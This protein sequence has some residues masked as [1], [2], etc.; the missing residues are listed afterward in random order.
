M[1]AI[2]FTLT[3]QIGSSVFAQEVEVMGKQGMMI[4]VPCVGFTNKRITTLHKGHYVKVIAERYTA[5][6]ANAQSNWKYIS[7]DDAVLG[8]R[9]NEGSQAQ[10]NWIVYLLL[11]DK[12]VPIIVP[13]SSQKEPQ[14]QA[15]G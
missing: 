2:E 9:T 4:R 3:N 15:T 13:R 1:A 10:G 6:N 14:L 5:D 11:D 12:G 7:V 8:W